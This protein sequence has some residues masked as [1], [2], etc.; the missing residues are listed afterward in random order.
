MSL[1]IVIVEDDADYGAKLESLL[2]Q[3]AGTT[4]LGRFESPLPLIESARALAGLGKL[5]WD[6]VL[7]DLCAPGM[8][9][10]EATRQLKVLLPDLPVII[11]T[12][13]ETPASLVRAIRPGS[14]G[15]LLTNTSTRE[16]LSHL[17]A[18]TVSTPSAPSPGVRQRFQ[19]QALRPSTLE[20]YARL[21]RRKRPT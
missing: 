13:F 16:L 15:H 12:V 18:L 4:V 20:L 5:P 2:T 6:L 11:F 9:G 8:N 14:D 21:M 3:E 7:M 19:V 1:R 17:R 10:I